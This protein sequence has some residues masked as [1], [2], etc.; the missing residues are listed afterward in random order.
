MNLFMRIAK[1][2]VF[3]LE[4]SFVLHHFLKKAIL[5]GLDIRIN[6]KKNMTE[7]C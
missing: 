4:I 1:F 7:N 5:A 3:S 6:N 2:R